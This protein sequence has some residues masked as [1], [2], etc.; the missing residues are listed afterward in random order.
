MRFLRPSVLVYMTTCQSIFFEFLRYENAIPQGTWI[1]D[2]LESNLAFGLVVK[3]LGITVKKEACD[4]VETLGCKKVFNPKAT[5]E[6]QK[7]NP[8][9]RAHFFLN[10]LNFEILKFW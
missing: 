10:F 6:F 9:K 2:Q 5:K 1:L 8:K 7:R 3:P 4:E